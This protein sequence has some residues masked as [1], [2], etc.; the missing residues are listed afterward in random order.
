M[1]VFGVQ[2]HNPLLC[3]GHYVGGWAGPQFDASPIANPVF[4]LL[5]QIEEFGDRLIGDFGRS[6]Q[7]AL[8]IGNA[9]DPAMLAATA[10]VAEVVLHVADDGV[11]PVEEV[12]C[13]I[14]ADFDVR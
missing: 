5:E 14:G 9:I 13:A 7:L 12:D 8:R 11:V 4:G 2:S 1:S 3:R 10:R 6:K